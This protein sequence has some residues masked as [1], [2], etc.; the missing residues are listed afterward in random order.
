MSEPVVIIG[1]EMS[2]RSR[3][4][5]LERPSRSTSS[6]FRFSPFSGAS[7]SVAPSPP[8]PPSSGTG[9]GSGSIPSG[10]LSQE[11]PT[12]SPSWSANPMWQCSGSCLACREPCHRLCPDR[13]CRDRHFRRY[14][15][16]P[17]QDFGH[18]GSC[19]ARPGCSRRPHRARAA[20]VH[21]R[22]QSHRPPSAT[23][24][25]G[26][27]FDVDHIS[28]AGAVGW[29]RLLRDPVLLAVA[30]VFRPRFD[31]RNDGEGNGHDQGEHAQE[32][33]RRG[34]SWH[35]LLP[36]SGRDASAKPTHEVPGS[37]GRLLY[38]NT[39]SQRLRVPLGYRCTNSVV[40]A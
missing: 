6:P 19:R 35:W 24:R 36:P 40:Y 5:D 31:H 4:L 20:L 22:H 25:R 12:P 27:I 1:F 38:P 23:V 3:C 15:H 32:R 34:S 10:D 30:L 37:A 8:S 9:S 26:P 18:W 13:P 14:P 11:S 17:D 7:S 2:V 16:R 39:R 33:T 21:W 28:L 29:H